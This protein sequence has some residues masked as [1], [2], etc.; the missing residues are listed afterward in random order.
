MPKQYER[1]RDSY[2]ERGKSL[3]EAKRLAAMF[4]NSHNKDDPNPWLREKR[5]KR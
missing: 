4:W 3:K 5:R 2:R 1:V